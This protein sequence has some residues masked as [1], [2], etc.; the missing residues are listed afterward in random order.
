MSLQNN[1]REIMAV[2]SILQQIVDTKKEEIRLQKQQLSLT[3]IKDSLQGMKPALNFE[4]K[5][6]EAIVQGR[7]AL[8]AEVK[9]ASPSK[10]LIR[11]DFDPK[12]IAKIYQQSGASAIS[13][14]TDEQ[15]FQGSLDYLKQV[16]E[17]VSIPVLRKDFIIDPYQVYQARYYGADFILLIQSI[18]S[19]SQFSEL[20]DLAKT[21]G[22][23]CLVETHRKE[24]FAFHQER[25]TP[26]IGINNRDLN[27]FKTDIEHTINLLKDKKSC[28]SHVISES[29]I[30]KFT[31]ILKL[32]NAGVAGILVGETFMREDDIAGAIQKMF[33]PS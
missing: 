12:R 27:T 1:K 13:V 16:S 28:V 4:D 24:E 25:K 14:L 33:S 32:S 18:L 8:I 29:G 10:G 11:P 20:E 22:M 3:K 31:D 2:A 6:K 21:L 19:E 9:K 7:M 23:H 5:I 26:I 15:Y 17:V 30:S